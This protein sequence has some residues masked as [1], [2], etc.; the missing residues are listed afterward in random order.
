[1]MTEVINDVKWK[2]GAYFGLLILLSGL[3]IYAFAYLKLNLPLA[4]V[5][6]FIGGGLF[7][8]IQT[9]T[10]I[11][12]LRILTKSDENRTLKESL[13]F[14][15]RKVNRMKMF[16][17]L[18]Y[19]LFFYLLASWVIYLHLKNIGGLKNIAAGNEIQP[20]I[21]VLLLLL[22]AIPWLMRYL[23][24]HRYKKLFSELNRSANY[25]NDAS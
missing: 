22:L 21:F 14:F 4:A 2:I 8:L 20:L 9:S 7:F 23:N 1:M 13:I 5:V 16:D 6:P 11:I 15:R 18:S 10:E 12:R 3:M 24:N 17:F 19:L 25:L